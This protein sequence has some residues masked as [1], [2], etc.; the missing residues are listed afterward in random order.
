MPSSVRDNQQL[1]RFDLDVDEQ[2]AFFSVQ[3]ATGSALA[4]GALEIAK[5]GADNQG[6][7]PP[8]WRPVSKSTRS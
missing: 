3:V 4:H 8:L 6:A 5:P 2:V 7:L 1:H